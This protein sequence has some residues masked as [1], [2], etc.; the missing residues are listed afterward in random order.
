MVGGMMS[1]AEL[2][3]LRQ[4][5]RKYDSRPVEAE[6]LRPLIEAVRLA[7][8]ACNSQPWTV[9]LVTDPDL[10][11]QVAQATF[12]AAIAFNKFAPE[13]PVIAVLTVEK[14]TLTSRVGGWLKGR[15][16][17]WIDLGAAAMQF[18]LQAAELGLGTCMIGWFDEGRIRALLHIPRAIRVGLLITVGYAAA[19]YAL[20]P[21]IRKDPAAMSRVNDYGES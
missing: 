17:P 2:F 20:R 7:P 5:V 10:K 9:I 15:E 8:S 3:Q 11:N 13:A 18:C 4:S 1:C 19:G 16:F 14:P 21:K 6:K 12:S